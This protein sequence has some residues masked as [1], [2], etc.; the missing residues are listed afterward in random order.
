MLLEANQLAA[1]DPVTDRLRARMDI[2]QRESVRRVLGIERDVTRTVRKLSKDVLAQSARASD[3][4]DAKQRFLKT[5]SK[6]TPALSKRL[7]DQ[8]E[9]IAHW[10]FRASVDAW[11]RS[12]PP[13]Y[14][15]S[16]VS[17]PQV[18]GESIQERKIDLGPLRV[19]VDFEPAT[20]KLKKRE[21]RALIAKMI[22]P[23]PS[24][25][26]VLKIL[27]GNI[28]GDGQSWADRIEG[29]SKKVTDLD[30]LANTLATAFN[31]GENI[32]QLS[33]I[34]RPF[35]DNIASSARRIARTEGLRIAET[36]QRE[37]FEMAGDVIAGFQVIATLDQ[38]TRPHHATRNGTIFW[39][40]GHGPAGAPTIDELPLLPD[41]P[42]CR[43]YT[44]PVLT[45]PEKFDSDPN[46]RVKFQN[47]AGKAI[48]DP[49]VYTQWFD[50]QHDRRKMDVVGVRRFRTIKDQLG[51][52]RKPD[53]LD[54]ISPE[55]GKLLP[56]AKL[57]DEDLRQRTERR[58]KLAALIQNRAAALRQVSRFG[59]TS[60]S[61]K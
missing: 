6:L 46:L 54:F 37:S 53:F 38:F 57:K 30:G 36:M 29:L 17:V 5:L 59:F 7:G 20:K 18:V 16:I 23:P 24:R 8:F 1:I 32:A 41:E 43:C 34:L 10:S 40:P 3:I 44:T 9:R 25:E 56:I 21:F 52:I 28:W 26:K 33:R 14:W 11:T 12:I 48:N 31:A 58:I 39:K 45:P 27:F 50:R 15:R 55:D 49:E 61:V 42:N 51:N 19:D 22:F 47:A 35:T 4:G 60:T 13:D 2:R